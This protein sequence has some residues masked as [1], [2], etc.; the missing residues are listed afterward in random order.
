MVLCYGSLLY[1]TFF[2]QYRVLRSVYVAFVHLV[3]PSL[4]PH[5]LAYCL[6]YVRCQISVHIINCIS[7][8]IRW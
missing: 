1:L 6:M 3:N 8:Y 7:E 5:Q 2:T 4:Y